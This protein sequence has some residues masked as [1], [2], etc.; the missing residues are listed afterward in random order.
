MADTQ[1]ERDKQNDYRKRLDELK[2]EYQRLTPTEIWEKAREYLYLY[3]EVRYCQMF[4]GTSSHETHDQAKSNL[5][6]EAIEQMVGRWELLKFELD[7]CEQD[8]RPR[9]SLEEYGQLMYGLEG[10]K[11]M[12]VDAMAYDVGRRVRDLLLR[13][14]PVEHV[15]YAE[16]PEA[17]RVLLF[18][19]DM[20][21]T[22][23]LLLYDDGFRCHTNDGNYNCDWANPDFFKILALALT[24]MCGYRVSSTD[25]CV[26]DGSV[27]AKTDGE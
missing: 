9:M 8:V 7:Y 22:G 15:S 11:T 10:M 19:Q 4:I 18:R 13:V 23:R 2:I 25:L 12:P 16:H 27:D 20:P 14:V 5:H 24:K 26:E 1:N 17:V 3:Y 21:R 6:L